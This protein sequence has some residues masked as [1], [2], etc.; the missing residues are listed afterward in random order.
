MGKKKRKKSNGNNDT[1]LNAYLQE[2]ADSLIWIES[3]LKPIVTTTKELLN[4]QS[5]FNFTFVFEEHSGELASIE[6]ASS[7]NVTP[8]MVED[9]HS[10]CIDLGETLS[11]W[12][13]KL[14]E[15]IHALDLSLVQMPGDIHKMLTDVRG[16]NWRP[17]VR[18]YLIL[19]LA[20][21]PAIP[22]REQWQINSSKFPVRPSI[23]TRLDK[24][25]ELTSEKD[26]SEEWQ[27]LCQRIRSFIDDIRVI[28]LELNSEAILEPDGPVG[29]R[30]WR[31]KGQTANRP[32]TETQD[33]LARYLWK[34]RNN[35]VSIS[36]LIGKDRLFEKVEDDT[37]R[38]HGSNI[39]TYFMNEGFPIAVETA[40]GDLWLTINKPEE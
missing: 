35:R 2:L 16:H 30:L 32:M 29:I 26:P 22:S 39:S 11:E 24:Y 15:R 7:N 19:P 34:K 17:Y 20:Y 38:R 9:F 13:K 28:A 27:A 5:K 25:L 10:I 8:E 37:V 18:R 3:L 36:T 40:D 4:N 12:L 21:W 6:T 14:P 33:R 23:P 1:Q 31:W